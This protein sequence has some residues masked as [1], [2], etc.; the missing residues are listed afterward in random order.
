MKESISVRLLEIA[1]ILAS[2]L[3]IALVGFGPLL[4]LHDRRA[5]IVQECQLFYG[6]SGSGA[7]A[8]CMAEMEQHA[9]A[10]GR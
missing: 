6:P 4:G 1:L 7:V 5:T 10:V 3:I 8:H 2:V 9:A